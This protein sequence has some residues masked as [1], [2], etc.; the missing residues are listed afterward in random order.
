MI[1]KNEVE[2]VLIKIGVPAANKGFRYIVDAMLIIDAD[3]NMSMTK[4]LYPAIASRNNT[5]GSRV[6]R[7]IR[8]AFETVRNRNENRGDVEHY[9]GSMHCSNGNTL[10]M[11]Y[12]A[13]KR[14]GDADFPADNKEIVGEEE[15]RRIVRKELKAILGG[16]V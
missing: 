11:L 5:T 8:H 6:E 13:I 16:A 7:C 3:P 9:L 12:I 15:I 2:D 1:Q 14:D 10:K 4:E